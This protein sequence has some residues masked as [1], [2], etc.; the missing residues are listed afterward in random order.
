M[1]QTPYRAVDVP[2]QGDASTMGEIF[3]WLHQ[4]SPIPNEILSLDSGETSL[5]VVERCGGLETRMNNR[6][7][8]MSTTFRLL[9]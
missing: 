8:G 2:D 6:N 9:L 7:R 1:S 4:L 3:N 5:F